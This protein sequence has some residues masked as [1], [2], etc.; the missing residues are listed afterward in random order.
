M[1]R[2]EDA[3]HLEVEGL[4]KRFPG[5]AEAAVDDVS[6][7]VRRGELVTLLGPSG[8]G[9][10]TTLRIIAGF[11]APDRGRVL[12]G[13]EDV[14]P[15]P[16]NRRGVGMVFQSYA[17]FPN[18]SVRENVAFGL[19]LRRQP[20][21]EIR[22]R[23]DELLALVRLGDLGDRPPH[24]LSGGQQQR[25]A[26]ARALA[27]EPQVLLL[28][29][30]LAAL[31]A[32]VRQELRV[33]IRR[34]QARLGT[35]TVYVTHDQ[36]EALSLSDRVVVMNRGHVEQVGSPEE[37]YGAP[38][39]AFVAGFV[40]R[41]NVLTATL[42]D[43]PTGTLKVASGSVTLGRPLHHAPGTA[44]RLAVRPE[45]LA[46]APAPSSGTPAAEAPSRLMGVVDEVEF[47]GAVVLVHVKAGDA[48]LTVQALN[49]PGTALP[50][51]GEKVT[52][53]VPPEAVLV[54]PVATET[55]AT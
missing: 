43:G 17:L 15:V 9:K 12:V 54:L 40:G 48:R 46:F 47:L 14:T 26:L 55:D 21:D 22:R 41:L 13:A 3:F 34:I 52:V 53:H 7:G 18:L 33:E 24:Q 16:A 31:D 32:V 19:R 11:E 10:S 45:N 39:T 2:A 37:I 1:T 27:I 51:V 49:A 25:V 42:I 6:F 8:C 38:R 23:V 28:D 4:G 29:E 35:T 20:D 30:P 36:E 50:R 44:V 5:A